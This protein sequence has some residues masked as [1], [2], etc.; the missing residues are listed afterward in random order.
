[1][2]WGGGGGGVFFLCWETGAVL[3]PS[4]GK[5]GREDLANGKKKEAGFIPAVQCP[6]KRRGGGKDIS[7]RNQTGREKEGKEGHLSLS[8]KKGG[9]KTKH[10]PPLSLPTSLPPARSQKEK[11]GGKHSILTHNGKCVRGRWKK[12]STSELS[13]RRSAREKKRE[14]PSSS[15][16]EGGGRSNQKKKVYGSI[17][18]CSR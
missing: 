7:R 3:P 6:K 18:P 4:G 1:V 17:I 11:E 10:R 8:L 2:G 16:K 12:K 15:W 5:G 14:K 13:I 9:E